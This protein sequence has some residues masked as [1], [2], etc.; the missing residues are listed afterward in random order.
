M[1]SL[2]RRKARTALAIL[3]IMTGAAIASA[4]FTTSFSLNDRMSRE[5]RA[6]GANIVVLP[7][8]N[9]IDIGLPGMAFDSVTDQGLIQ[10]SEL[11]RI[12]MIPN[13][14][15]NV[16]GYAPFLYQV[17]S[18]NSS[19]TGQPVKVAL[20]G[21][22]FVH[23][24]PKVAAGWTT[25]LRYIAAWWHVRGGWVKG[26]SDHNGSMVG[27][28]VARELGLQ[29]GST[30]RAAYSNPATR[31]AAGRDFVVRGIVSTGGNEDDQL[32]VNLAEAQELSF[33]PG[34]VHAVYVSALC[35]ACPAEMMAEEIQMSL[36]VNAKSVRQIVGSERTIVAGLDRLMFLTSAAAIVASALV[37]MTAMT[38]GVIERRREIGIMKAVGASNWTIAAVFLGEAVALGSLGGLAGSVAGIALAQAVSNGVFGVA[39]VLPPV[40]LPLTVGLSVAVAAGA[41]AMPIRRA[42]DVRPATVLRGD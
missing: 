36:P 27:A 28:N 31:Q 19:V 24:E 26:D 1:R 5:F 33:R 16:L 10:E 21:T 12:K 41:S 40:V 23:V 22:Y 13:W 17:V 7:A 14:S 32:F 42:L 20:A 11:W 39:V 3:A 29:I 8:S 15:A 2:T 34:R 4:L 37:V 25:G 6:F 30:Y 38:T 35:S 18:V 9:T